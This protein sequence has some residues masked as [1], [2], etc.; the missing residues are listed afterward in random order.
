MNVLWSGFDTLE[1]AYFG[2]VDQPWQEHLE[3]AK[4]QARSKQRPEPVVVGGQRFGVLRQGLKP[5]AWVL[6]HPDLHVRLGRSK[7]AS[8]VRCLSLGLAAFG[9]ERVLAQADAVLSAVGS[10]GLARVSRCDVAVDFQGWVP[11]AAESSDATCP[12]TFR[13]IYPSLADPETF[14]F[15]KGGIV[16]R[17][18]NKTRE[19]AGTASHWPGVWA[20]CDA[21]DPANDVWRVEFQYRASVLRE[22]GLRRPDEVLRAASDLMDYGMRWLTYRTPTGDSNRR[23]W[24]VHPGWSALREGFVVSDPVSRARDVAGSG[25]A[26][27]LVPQA[28]GLLVSI[29]AH[30][31]IKCPA[32][33]T[34]WLLAAMGD[35]HAE[36][37][38]DFERLVSDRQLDLYGVTTADGLPPSFAYTGL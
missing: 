10:F 2:A 14:Q 35:Y 25:S 6:T 4:Q 27:S 36:R 38:T 28:S 32:E 11:S 23:R 30:L 20:A 18:Y 3:C 8:G 12:A 17:V 22:L 33:A 24:P 16:A 34:R 37:G 7:V 21:Y 15:G 29:G 1:V 13:P 19:V 26:Y 9:P 5:W 31:G